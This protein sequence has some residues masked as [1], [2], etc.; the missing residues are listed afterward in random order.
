[1]SDGLNARI[2]NVKGRLAA[3]DDDCGDGGPEAE[4]ALNRFEG[5][6]GLRLPEDYRAFMAAI[7]RLPALFPHYGMV[8]PGLPAGAGFDAPT[9]PTPQNPFRS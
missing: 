1:M 4:A 3:L 7:G 2:A 5:R 8:P 9:P 6:T